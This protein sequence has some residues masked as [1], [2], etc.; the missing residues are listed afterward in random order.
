VEEKEM[1]HATYAA[2]VYKENEFQHMVTLKTLESGTPRRL[3]LV[4][5]KSWYRLL[6]EESNIKE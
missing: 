3:T 4:A 6:S 5:M 2:T 1:L